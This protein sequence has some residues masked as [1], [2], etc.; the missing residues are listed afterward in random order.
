MFLEYGVNDHGELVRIDETGRGRLDGV[1]CPYC[2]RPL[3]ARKG[4]VLA[5][6]F[7]HDGETCRAA[8]RD[9]DV[10]N[11]PVYDR[12]LLHLSPAE[13]QALRVAAGDRSV[14]PS[15][16]TLSLR[17]RL[18]DKGVIA[19]NTYTRST[20]VTKLGKI[21]L[22]KLSLMLFCDVQE[23]LIRQR[24]EE[25]EDAAYRAI[26]T[27]D[28]ATAITDL[29]LYRA[30]WQRVLSLTLYFLEIT[31]TGGVLHKIGVT[32]RAVDARAAEVAAD[33]RAA[34]LQGVSVKV[35]DTWSH[36]GNVELYFKY[37]YATQQQRINALTEYFQFADVKS[38]LRD[39]RRMKPKTLDAL[40]M[41]VASGA[42]SR[43]ERGE[44]REVLA[45]EDYHF[46]ERC[47]REVSDPSEA[48]NMAATIWRRNWSYDP[49]PVAVYADHF[50]DWYHRHYAAEFEEWQRLQLE[51][52][53]AKEAADRA[54][55]RRDAIRLGM[56]AAADRG[57]RV[58]RP[59]DDPAQIVA[60]Y[61]AVV[62][63]LQSGL[64]LRGAASA[65]GVAVN[66][67]R[68]VKQAIDTLKENQKPHGQ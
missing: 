26:N 33:L 31:H 61:P 8:D 9:A 19:D 37:R 40:E 55:A 68:K 35:V 1:Y 38:V 49:Y 50:G 21:P 28:Y 39:L 2:R 53:A 54:A 18:Y 34:E 36:R 16:S 62:A 29:Q 59:A 30:Q 66:T 11:L 15:E 4:K 17:Q 7:A 13:L 12:F 41:E 47:A 5:P 10:I 45:F 32:N 25:L 20:E 52:Q 46:I 48:K 51:K 27:A 44:P 22:G 58:G 60:S 67:V 43:L 14:S 3:L 63:A 6:H 65:A 64:S 42:P 24:H 57:Q 23:P 56:Q